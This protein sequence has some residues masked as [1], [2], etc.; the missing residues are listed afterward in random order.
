MA[1]AHRNTQTAT[2]DEAIA[3]AG[4]TGTRTVTP[5]SAAGNAT[6]TVA[7]RPAS[8]ARRRLAVV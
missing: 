5:S 2:A 4:A 3:S 1:I 8:D 7:L 6:I